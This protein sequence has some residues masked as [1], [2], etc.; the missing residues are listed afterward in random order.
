MVAEGPSQWDGFLNDGEGISKEMSGIRSE[1]KETDEIREREKRRARE[2]LKKE[3]LLQ[4][5]ARLD[6]ENIS[7]ANKKRNELLSRIYQAKAKEDQAFRA[8]LP[9][10]SPQYVHDATYFYY[11]EINLER[12]RL[13]GLT[14]NEIYFKHR[15]ICDRITELIRLRELDFKN[16]QTRWAEWLVFDK[17]ASKIHRNQTDPLHGFYNS[18][19]CNISNCFEALAFLLCLI[20]GG[21]LIFIACLFVYG[22]FMWG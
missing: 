8:D 6:A 22:I 4:E 21:W 15:D 2:E 17:K 5:K 10:L 7:S 13:S 19:K 14:D 3:K 12:Q 20:V 18:I 1:L 16:P 11:R 9:H